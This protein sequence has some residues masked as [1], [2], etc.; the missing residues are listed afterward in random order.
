VN[1]P[2]YSDLWFTVNHNNC[3]LFSDINIPQGSVATHLQC[4]GIV[5]YHSTANLSLSLTMKEFWKSVKI[6]HSYRHEFGG[7]V[8]FW[9]HSVYIVCCVHCMLPHL[10]F[11][12]HFFHTCLHSY[13]FFPSRIY[14]LH[15]QARDRKRRP[16][17]G[18]FSCF[19]LFLWSPYVIGQ[20][21][22]FLPCDFFL[23]SFFF[24]A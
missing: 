20:T 5:I 9:E 10:S 6:W 24:L 23:S 19:S 13:L 22:T 3:Y 2:S 18:F 21:I 16:N 15:F 8:F 14:P 11:F 12:I 4:G 7:P 1:L 17:V